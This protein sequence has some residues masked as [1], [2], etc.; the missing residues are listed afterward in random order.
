VKSGGGN[1]VNKHR[2]KSEQQTTLSAKWRRGAGVAAAGSAFSALSSALGGG[3]C[4]AASKIMA[5]RVNNGQ[6]SA[7][8]AKNDALSL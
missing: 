2:Q 4:R 7:K 5:W 6:T 8:I 3:F 1:G